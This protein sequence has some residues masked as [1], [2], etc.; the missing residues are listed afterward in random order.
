MHE[1]RYQVFISSTYEDLKSERSAVQ[2]AVI[3]TGDF[4]VQ[5]ESFPAADE[6][7][8]EFIKTLIDKCDYYILIIA[9]RYGSIADD[10]LSYTHKEFRYATSKNVP[11]LVMVHAHRGNISANRSEQ[12]PLGKEKLAKFILEA[13]TGRLRKIWNTTDGLKLAVREAL[14]YAKA[15][16]PGVGWVRGD[17]ATNLETLEE[18]NSIRKQNEEFRRTLGELN[19]DIELPSIPAADDALELEFLP[20]SANSSRDR[21]RAGSYAKIKGTWIAAFPSFFDNLKWH[22]S[23]W[24]GEFNFY[25]EN[26]ESCVAIGSA[27]AGELA[28]I[29]TTGMFRLRKSALERLSSYYIEAGLM[30]GEGE[31]PFTEAANRIARRFRISGSASAAFSLLQGKVEVNEAVA[32]LTDID[33]DIPF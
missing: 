15:T 12:D 9:G 4:P 17:S 21:G 2:D 26:D 16:N 18:L 23:D 32:G 28:N 20:M 31:H 6:D 10:G 27:L 19:I 24:N 8:F 25:I 7:Q 14:D 33:D 1:K 29:D 5:M 13:E 22:S 3:S 11:I 30:R